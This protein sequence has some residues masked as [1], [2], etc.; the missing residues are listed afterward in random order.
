MPDPLVATVIVVV[1]LLNN[2]DAPLIGAVNVTFTPGSRLLPTS[3]TVTVSAFA[4]AALIAE[5]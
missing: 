3:F 4:K 2:P 5:L 1:L